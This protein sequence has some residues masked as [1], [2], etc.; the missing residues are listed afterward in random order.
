MYGVIRIQTEWEGF[1]DGE[2]K[3]ALCVTSIWLRD[4]V[5]SAVFRTLDYGKK[6]ICFYLM[7]RPLFQYSH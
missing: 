6:E 7:Q 2:K 1:I 5:I 4:S 3:T